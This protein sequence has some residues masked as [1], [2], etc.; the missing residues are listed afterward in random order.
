MA[1][2][3]PNRGPHDRTRIVSTTD[4][5]ELRYWTQE[6]GVSADR[7]KELVVQHG[8]CAEK[9][10]EAVAACEHGLGVSR[11]N[12]EPRLVNKA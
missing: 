4:E 9:V 2:D 8:N 1:T 11:S 10:R 5:E 6:L 12:R 3:T 7:L